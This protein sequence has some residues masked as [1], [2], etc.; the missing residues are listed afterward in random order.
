MPTRRRP[1]IL[2]LLAGAAIGFG[3]GDVAFPELEELIGD[4]LCDFILG[5]GGAALA[6]VGFEVAASFSA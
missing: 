5:A 6:G 2:T 1:Y 4:P 3:L